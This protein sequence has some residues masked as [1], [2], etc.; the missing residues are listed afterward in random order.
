[1]RVRGP[2]GECSS[3]GN[4]AGTKFEATTLTDSWYF[5]AESK[6][7]CS[8]WIKDVVLWRDHANFVLY[9]KKLCRHLRGRRRRGCAGGGG[10][11]E[12]EEQGW[13]CHR[14]QPQQKEKSKKPKSKNRQGSLLDPLGLLG[15]GGGDGNGEDE[16]TKQA[17]GS[18][19]SSKKGPPSHIGNLLSG[20]GGEVERYG[21]ASSTEDGSALGSA[22]ESQGDLDDGEEDGNDPDSG[23]DGE[24]GDY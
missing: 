17:S 8:A 11:C 5:K 7:V 15:L 22:L 2:S 9:E 20:D 3:T 24:E 4:A 16:T 12:R 14:Q 6:E 19:R 10:E 18:V 13:W 23:T 21:D 1:V